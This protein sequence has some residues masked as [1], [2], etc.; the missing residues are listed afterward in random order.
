MNTIRFVGMR[1]TK[2]EKLKHILRRIE[3][4]DDL[5]D[6][7]SDDLIDLSEYL[8]LF[9]KKRVE[10]LYYTDTDLINEHPEDL[11]I[12]KIYI[13]EIDSCGDY[14]MFPYEIHGMD[15]EEELKFEEQKDTRGYFNRVNLKSHKNKK[16]SFEQMKTE[17]LIA[18]KRHKEKLKGRKKIKRKNLVGDK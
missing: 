6:D 5:S 17:R 9:P 11:D 18:S 3:L 2:D 12:Q 10:Q 14:W 16:K 8:K 13:D 15:S 1:T 7:L 4:I